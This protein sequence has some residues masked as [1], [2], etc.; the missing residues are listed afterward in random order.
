MDRRISGEN[1]ISTATCIFRALFSPRERLCAGGK[2]GGKRKA[3]DVNFLESVFPSR[4]FYRTASFLHNFLQFFALKSVSATLDCCANRISDSFS[5][6]FN[7]VDFA[8]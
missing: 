1:G 6:I 8:L 2:K 5:V 4:E 7:L 3:V